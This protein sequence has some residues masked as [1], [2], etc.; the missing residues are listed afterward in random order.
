M[1]VRVSSYFLGVCSIH[2]PE[3]VLSW[4]RTVLSIRI[5]NRCFNIIVLYVQQ[6]WILVVP[7]RHA[8]RLGSSDTFQGCQSCPSNRKTASCNACSKVNAVAD[9]WARH[10]MAKEHTTHSS[11]IIVTIY[12]LQPGFLSLRKE[13]PLPE[14]SPQTPVSSYSWPR[15][16][17]VV[18]KAVSPSCFRSSL[19]SNIYI[20]I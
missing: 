11:L 4:V 14:L 10:H 12:H 3:W 9:D 1:Q 16:T 15:R 17:Q 6:V 7:F 20:I 2:R 13:E 18:D 5:K 19:P 8:R